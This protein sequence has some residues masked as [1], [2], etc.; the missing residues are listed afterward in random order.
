VLDLIPYIGIGRYVQA[1]TGSQ[2]I[3]KFGDARA[4]PDF[5]CRFFS[6][7]PAFFRQLFNH[8]VALR[9]IV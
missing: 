9:M 5:V 1:K 6:Q 7:A 4:A 8:F 2:S 3:Q